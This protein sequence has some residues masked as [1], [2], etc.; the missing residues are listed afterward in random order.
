MIDLKLKSKEDIFHVICGVS[1]SN[2][3]DAWCQ[4]LYL[5]SLEC[6][7]NFK[8]KV[9]LKDNFSPKEDTNVSSLGSVVEQETETKFLAPHRGQE[10]ALSHSQRCLSTLSLLDLLKED[11]NIPRKHPLCVQL[12]GAQSSG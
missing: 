8:V 2:I 1:W 4:V 12:L 5:L 10:W 7:L 11:R 9:Y 3:Q 6:P